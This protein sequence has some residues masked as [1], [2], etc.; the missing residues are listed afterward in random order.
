MGLDYSIEVGIRDRRTN[1]DVAEIEI[2]YWRKCYSLRSE[3]MLVALKDEDK[4][5]RRDSDYFI[6][7]TIDVLED[8]IKFLSAAIPDEDND[9]FTQSIWG[10]IVARMITVKQLE[11][12]I[13]W[14][15]LFLR[16]PDIIDDDKETR[17]LRLEE[18]EDIDILKYIEYDMTKTG[19]GSGTIDLKGIL[20]DIENY[21]F[22]LRIYNSY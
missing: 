10:G 6:E 14:H 18:L 15:S 17:K 2:G 3:T 13:P 22:T 12:M 21:Q 5:L 4:V 8:I 7:T 20:M 19:N 11:R 1:S 9:I 16:F